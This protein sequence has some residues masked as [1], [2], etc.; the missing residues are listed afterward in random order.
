MVSSGDNFLAGPEF[1]ASLQKGVPYFDAI[2]MDLIRYQA[3]AIGNHEF[4]F[5][6]DV[7]ADFIESFLKTMPPPPFLSSNLD[8]SAEPRLHALVKDH[9]IAKSLLIRRHGVQFGIIGA[10]TTN[11]RSISSPRNVVVLEDVA[12]AVQ[13]EVDALEA[14]GVNMIILTSHLQDID[15]DLA[16]IGRISLSGRRPST[17]IVITITP[18]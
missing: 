10:T 14:R 15:T 9:R 3:I 18:V 8:F 17:V 13:A 6:P 5:G 16:L 12:A 1:N 4:D 2:A 7:L 11:L